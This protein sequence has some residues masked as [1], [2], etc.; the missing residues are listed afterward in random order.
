MDTPRKN[1]IFLQEFVSKIKP[2]LSQRLEVFIALC[3]EVRRFHGQ[4]MV[5]ND[6]HFNAFR[7]HP[8]TFSVEI[9][10]SS[11]MLDLSARPTDSILKT[12]GQIA[13]FSPERTG[14][15]AYPVDFRSDLYSM[16]VVLYRLLTDRLP[17]DSMDPLKTIHA[18]IALPAVPV[19]RINPKIPPTVSLIATRLLAKSPEDRYQSASGLIFDLKKALEQ[20]RT[21]GKIDRFPLGQRDFAPF[22]KIPDRLYGRHKEVAL[23]CDAYK[24]VCKGTAE[25]VFINGPPG[26]GKSFLVNHIQPYLLEN[27]GFFYSGKFDQYEQT[28]PYS[29]IVQVFT[30]LIHRMLTLSEA[31]L[32]GKRN[33]ILGAVGQNG[34]LIID[35]IPELELVIGKQEPTEKLSSPEN[36]NR[37]KY[38]FQNFVRAITQETNPVIIFL[39]D[40][41]WADRASLELMEAIISDSAL[42]NVLFIC[43]YRDIE[44]KKNSFLADFLKNLARNTH[45]SSQFVVLEPVDNEYIETLIKDMLSIDPD[46]GRDVI[47]L[48]AQKT[49]CNPLFIKEFLIHLHKEGLIRFIQTKNEAEAD[50]WDIDLNGIIKARLP[51]TIVA[52]L[53]ERIRNLS[54]ETQEILNIAACIGTKFTPELIKAVYKSAIEVIRPH[55]K[56]ALDQGIIVPIE[57]G[58][59]F[60]HDRVREAVYESNTIEKRIGTHYAVGRAVLTETPEKQSDNIFLLVSQLNSARPLLSAGECDELIRL[61]LAAG[62]KAKE[63]AAFAIAQE[64]FASSLELLDR[65]AWKHNYEL[66]LVLH[67]EAAETAYMCAEF[68]AAEKLVQTVLKNALNDLDQVPAYNI[69]ISCLLS[70][71]KFPEI[72]ETGSHLLGR[73]GYRLPIN[74]GRLR[75]LWENFLLKWTLRKKTLKQLRELKYTQDTKILAQNRIIGSIISPAYRSRPIVFRFIV[76]NSL[77]RSLK[78]GCTP[79]IALYFSYY[80]LLL[81]TAGKMDRGY[82]MGQVALTLSNH[83]EISPNSKTQI[84]LP[85][86]G[87]ILLWKKHFNATLQPLLT[88]Y[89]Y[90]LENGD[91][92]A[93][94]TTISLYFNNLVACGTPLKE[95]L[96]EIDFHYDIMRQ[97]RQQTA[98]GY[99]SGLRYQLLSNFVG[100]VEETH[101]RHFCDFD[102]EAFLATLTTSHDKLSLSYIYFSRLVGNYYRGSYWKAIQNSQLASKIYKKTTPSV[103][104]MRLK[105]YD[106]LARIAHIRAMTTAANGG[107]ITYWDALKSFCS[108]RYHLA[109]VAS[110]QRC[111]RSWSLLAPMNFLSKWNLVEAER[112]NLSGQKNRAETHYHEAITLAGKHGFMHEEALSNELLARFY[113]KNGR[114]K[115]AQRYFKA[116]IDL[117]QKWGAEIQSRQLLKEYRTHFGSLLE[118]AENNSAQKSE[119]H[120]VAPQESLTPA[121]MDLRLISNVMETISSNVNMQER[122]VILSKHIMQYSGAQRVLLLLNKERLHIGVDNEILKE[123][124]ALKPVDTDSIFPYTIISYVIRTREPVLLSHAAKSEIFSA[125]PYLHTRNAKSVICIPLIYE[126]RLEALLYLENNLSSGIFTHQHEEIL[127]RLGKQIALFLQNEFFKKKISEDSGH[128]LPPQQLIIVLQDRFGLTPQEAKIATLFREGHTREQ[129]RKMLNISS[130]TLRKHLQTIFKKTVNLKEKSSLPGRVDKL[131]RLIFFLFKQSSVT[132]D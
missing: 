18:H 128:I 96:A 8:V 118:K 74:P 109:K 65:S 53:T 101:P 63:M 17:F 131:S 111:L 3:E 56:E 36:L 58:Y 66:A 86:N 6:I 31:A 70:Q 120:C 90:C 40:L 68:D 35:V 100:V 130:T 2:D 32:E 22:F 114:K 80:S 106:S 21:K 38:L 92:T 34:Q 87:L 122:L 14:K 89:K 119:E 78:R 41:Q 93:A 50:R 54:E 39:D 71:N 25:A 4:E 49:N 107:S 104:A 94:S 67:T 48:I 88:T 75:L 44:A 108:R 23:I 69:H 121:E 110:N 13:Y 103:N 30:G 73:L 84:L 45:I 82:D 83:P 52:L 11:L 76:L 43:A 126:D 115:A 51:E 24:K 7:I 98:F 5:H 29:A 16:G 116:A 105:F 42:C 97:C 127:M 20:L 26:I 12:G 129:I 113:L 132:N 19:D 55:L 85:V 124:S 60:I 64:Y 10:N 33:A 79:E 28:I 1:K 57:N 9:S 59:Q 95:I 102:E 15:T 99:F 46:H 47:Q 37:F 62:K 117:N 91:L 77:R 61:N 72:I 125:D 81:G 123:P 27:G 112:V